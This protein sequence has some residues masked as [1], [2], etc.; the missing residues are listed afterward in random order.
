MSTR[1]LS[2][3]ALMSEQAHASTVRTEESR[4]LRGR[5]VPAKQRVEIRGLT[6]VA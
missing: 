1:I 6:Q 3:H 4:S 2:V 5:L